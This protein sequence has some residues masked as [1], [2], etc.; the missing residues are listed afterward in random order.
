MQIKTMP[1]KKSDQPES[2][3]SGM[4][5]IT[6]TKKDN[7]YSLSYTI[8]PVDI[9]AKMDANIVHLG[10]FPDKNSVVIDCTDEGDLPSSVFYFLVKV[11]MRRKTS[12]PSAAEQGFGPS[13]RK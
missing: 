11:S 10:I 3:W 12:T 5:I 8:A 7:G 1:V 6:S 9:V 4:S 13:P 2:H